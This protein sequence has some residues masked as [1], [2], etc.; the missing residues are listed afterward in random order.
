MSKIT[1]T[2]FAI[3]KNEEK[4]IERCL[5]SLLPIIDYI[6]ISDTGSTDNT[7]E[8]IQNFI[9]KSGKKGKVFQDTWV[10]FGVNRTLS[11]EN[12]QKWIK[13]E[14]INQ[15]SNYLLTID[16]DMCLN[17]DPSFNKDILINSECW[18]CRQLN[19]VLCYY[20]SR[21]FRS[22]LPV[23]C[24]G[25]THEFWYYENIGKNNKKLET[26]TLKDIGDGGAKSD[27]YTRD[28]K[29][30]LKGIEDEPQNTR[31]F[32][33]LGQSY[34]DSGD[35][36]LSEK[37]YLK[38]VESKGW[39]EELL[40][41]C[42]R[43]GEIYMKW[44]NPEKALSIWA[45]GY[46]YNPK[47]AESLVRIANYYRMSK[48]YGLALLYLRELVKIEYPRDQVLFI[49]YKV[50]EYSIYEELCTVSLFVGNRDCGLMSCNYLILKKEDD[51]KGNGP[52]PLSE[53]KK[54][55]YYN[56][57][58]FIKPFNWNYKTVFN[59]PDIKNI[60]K[61]SSIS[62]FLPKN[63]NHKS[64]GS[65]ENISITGVVR[66]VNYS[67]NDNLEYTI[68]DINNTIRTKN[69]WVSFKK[70]KSG[71]GLIL[72]TMYELECNAPKIRSSLVASGLEDLRVIEIGKRIF[73]LAVDWERGK[74]EQPS[75]V[76]THIEQDKSGKMFISQVVP[77]RFQDNL[78]QKNWVP[79]TSNGMFLV[80]YSHQPLIILELNPDTGE[81]KIIYNKLQK[82]DLSG[83]RG[84]STPFQMKNGDWI[85][86]V[87]EIFQITSKPRVYYNR[88]LR[89]SPNW[90]L[91]SVSNPFIFEKL[92]VE[93][94]LSIY[95]ES[96]IL[97]IPYSSRDNSTEMVSIEIDKIPWVPD[98]SKMKEWI[99]KHI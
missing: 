41:A 19:D 69:Y 25:V 82:Y 49:E 96:D 60:W 11:F 52:S 31:Y 89:Y 18:M 20:N 55:G 50:Y 83:I 48:K 45:D 40:I 77:T 74:I 51:T 33:Y 9:D 15:R 22:D 13:G 65:E 97:Y 64:N 34:F 71:K 16:A 5:Q 95:V 4:I 91:I 3:V 94:C 17:I 84:S 26:L 86:V 38:L 36:E 98:L 43:L 8:K 76:I 63:F 70:E 61:S 99:R 81:E 92:F 67:M 30:L 56:I 90:D 21:L 44:E 78:Q 62:L 75:I 39:D 27:K 93:F 46:H 14:N 28:I 6:V 80:I 29:L 7:I 58:G 68:R 1:I 54:L 85:L 23:K 88:I 72:K 35:L 2:F 42:T 53:L 47:R 37:W 12:A 87:H 79:F 10:N 59:F 57:I 73:G 24:I 32:F 66:A